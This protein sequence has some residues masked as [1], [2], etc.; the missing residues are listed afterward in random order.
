MIAKNDCG[1]TGVIRLPSALRGSKE[2][3]SRI[4]PGHV[5]RQKSYRDLGTLRRDDWSRAK[6]DDFLPKYISRW[7][8]GILN[9]GTYRKLILQTF[10]QILH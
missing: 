7:E 1:M 5:H 9:V 3:Q 6:N 8:L 4:T 10:H 2:W